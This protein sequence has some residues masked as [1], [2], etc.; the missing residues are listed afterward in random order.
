[1]S[2][3]RCLLVRYFR[4]S[5]EPAV[6]RWSGEGSRWYLS[7]SF[8]RAV[9]VFLR[10]GWGMRHSMP[11]A[12]QLVQG[13]PSEAASHRTY[14]RVEHGREQV[15]RLAVDYSPSW[16]GMLRCVV[17]SIRHSSLEVWVDRGAEARAA[18]HLSHRPQ[19]RPLS[20]IR[21]FAQMDS[22]HFRTLDWR[23]VAGTRHGLGRRTRTAPAPATLRTAWLLV[24]IHSLAL[25]RESTYGEPL[26]LG[27][28]AS[29]GGAADGAGTLL[30]MNE[31][32]PAMVSRL[33]L[34]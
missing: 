21:G 14:G 4:V 20:C 1:M 27:C 6:T 7:P 29:G 17:V 18:D 32:S 31:C 19:Q 2:G 10:L 26:L 12:V 16:R 3:R 9:C 23:V 11:K 8:A 33:F 13:M 34:C 22:T 24:S 28:A 30:A 15:E 25:G 5:L